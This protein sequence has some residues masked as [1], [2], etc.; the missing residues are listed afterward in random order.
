MQTRD[1]RLTFRF[2]DFALD[3]AA[4]E[5]RRRGRPVK[6]GRQPMDLLILLVEGRRQLVSRSDIVD[7]LWGKD[8]FV[9][10]DTGVNTAISK[11]RQALRD[12]PEAP[13]FV[14]T[15]PGKGYRF[16]ATVET[17]FPS[18][19]L[20]SGGPEPDLSP[21]R[22]E[23]SG[24]GSEPAQPHAQPAAAPSTS[25]ESAVARTVETIGPSGS[26]S[27]SRSR[28]AV[29]LS[30]V[31]VA[32]AIVAFTRLKG[33]GVGSSVTLAVLPFANLGS[34]P[35]REYLAA[36]LTDETSASLAQ[37]DP[38]HLSVKGRTLRYKGTTKTAAEIGQELSVDYLVESSIRAEGARLRV[39]VTLIRV[40]DQEH[41]WSQFYDREPTSLLGLQQEL[42]TA[43]AEQV[44]LRLS[45]DRM[46]GLGRRQTQNEE[47]YDAYLRGRYQ[48]NR[49]T[50]DGN[51]RAIELFNRALAIDPN[52]ALAW[53]DLAFAY[54]AGTINGDARP[55]DVGPR[56]RA[57]ALNAVRANP[58]LSEAQLARGYDLWMIEWDWKAAESALR[59]AVDLDPSNATA[60]RILGH[61]LSQF[62]QQAEADTAM[63]RARELDPLDATNRG[64][65]SVVAFQGRD[66]AAAIEHAR[67]AISLDP[68]LWI[69]YIGLGQAYELAGDHALA[70]E[71]L[72]DAARLPGGGN[73]K[74]LSL[75]GYIL[76]RMGRADAAREVLATLEA[77][78][79]ER[80]VPPY[81][82][83]LVYAGLGE[84]EAMFDALEKAYAVRD[85][86]LI[87]L[88][89]GAQWDPYR[90]DPR[91]V[92]LLARCG[93][94]SSR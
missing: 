41:V 73:S 90:T 20:A 1:S 52:Y 88:P 42:S 93:F 10:V 15:V 16:I 43:I 37:I 3:V 27:G 39:T 19:D 47:A 51:A 25:A 24:N 7:R 18:T 63:R 2:G 28:L 46:S 76:A 74:V 56:A 32:I 62:G 54:G 31:V 92:D 79:R 22:R 8:V 71:A 4:Y 72:A 35:E 23:V 45:P 55:A 65:S 34:D 49:R 13:A 33:G 12:S 59:L 53:S 87:Y 64:L 48:I 81:A 61:A 77:L 91:F 21:T 86:H 67:R 80:Y 14:E 9:D 40:R 58:D 78:S 44:R 82:S 30:I 75:K 17:V 69:G 68:G 94:R 85:V 50:P 57:A 6:L 89:V 26:R 11:I 60:H 83:A 66:A 70:L 38:A 29:G 84:R 36:G 5:L